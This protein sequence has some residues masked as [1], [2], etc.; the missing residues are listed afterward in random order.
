MLIQNAKRDRMSTNQALEQ[1][2]SEN[3]LSFNPTQ[4]IRMSELKS[5]LDQLARKLTLKRDAGQL[6]NWIVA[7]TGYL[8]YFL[9][10][11][12]KGEHA[13]EKVQAV[14]NFL[15]YISHTRVTPLG[16]LDLIA[17]LDTTHGAPK[18][19]QIVFTTIFRTKGLEF[20]YVVL[21]KCDEN[22]LPYLK[23][24]RTAIYDTSHLYKE[25][26]ISDRIE[27]ERRLCYVAIT[28]ARKGVF[29]GT[30]DNPSRFIQ[31]L[32]LQ[33]GVTI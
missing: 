4:R 17:R 1:T 6:L 20:D 25:A 13:D 16:L 12:G 32:Q 5:V 15:E 2:L 22:A 19:D 33:E 28:R 24:E 8:S 21:P 11:Y 14:L 9:D 18:E 3:G 7:E 31:E 29:I 30:S 27:S 26:Q 10:Y 23:G